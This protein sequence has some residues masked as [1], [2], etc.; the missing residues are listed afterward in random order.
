M[1]DGVKVIHVRPKDQGEFLPKG[2]LTIA[3]RWVR[4]MSYIE[5]ATAY[6]SDQDVFKRRVGNDMAKSA[7]SNGAFIRIPF[8]K[9]QRSYS[10]P[11]SV[12]RSAFLNS[13]GAI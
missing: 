12:V 10:T 11:T 2:G 4:G 5:V 8:T 13:Y 1:T 9:E 7:L 6:C 3:Y